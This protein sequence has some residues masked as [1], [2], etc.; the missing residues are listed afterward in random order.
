MTNRLKAGFL[1][2]CMS[3][4][5]SACGDGSEPYEGTTL[6]RGL[7]GEPDNFDQH[8]N[9]SVQGHRV[10]IDLFEGLLRYSASGEL[11]GGVAES[12]SVSDDGMVYR[13]DLRSDAKWSNGE[14]ITAND[15]VF[16]FRRLVNPE[17][18]AFYADFVSMIENAK[19][20]V[21][22]ELPVTELGVDA[23]D[24][25]TLVIRLEKPTPYF[26]QLLTHPSTS[27]LNARSIE[28]HG[29]RFTRPGNLVSNGAYKLDS[30]TLGS[31]T[32]LTK[33]EFYWERDTVKID[34]VRYIKI[35]SEEA[36]Y[37][38]YRAGE[39]HITGTVPSSKFE[40]IREERP[41]EL[42]VAPQLGVY[43][44]GFNM[45]KEPF[46]NNKKLRQ[47][48]SMAIDRDILVTAVTRRGELPAYSWVPPGIE[49]YDPPGFTYKGMSKAQREAEAKRLYKEA[50]YSEENPVSF[51]LRYNIGENEQ[52]IAVAIQS[53]WKEVLGADVE[54]VNEEFQTLLSNIRGM[55]VTQLFRLSWIGDY[56]DPHTFLD[57]L[58]SGSPQNM[59]GYSNTEFDRLMEEA[60]LELNTKKRLALLERAEA[61]ILQDHPVIPLYYYVSKHLV[62]E[63]VKGWQETT[64][65]FHP[66]QF[67]WLDQGASR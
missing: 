67:L 54:L 41:N 40:A 66:S 16:S 1:T 51:E 20:I 4:V 57:L 38:Q 45:K 30:Y 26:P 28:E 64:I 48:L 56:F 15:F 32:T 5:I 18:G 11:E 21:A 42:R 3:I 47:A 13:F 61:I 33:N 60:A 46:A 55:Q 2:L 50:G 6:N 53:M 44:Y 59:T 14:P 25:R 22:G 7:V 12:W 65:D 43:Y 17:T 27:P 19:Q 23:I 36:M 39:L 24:D 52:L 29:D 35:V 63:E 31:L 37:N 8:A 49:G 10:L 62:K 58:D 34:K 9:R